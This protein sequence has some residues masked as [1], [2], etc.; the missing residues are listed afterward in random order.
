M[1]SRNLLPIQR[2][3]AKRRQRAIRRWLLINSIYLVILGI[4]GAVSP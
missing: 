4:I 1:N 2:Q 3:T